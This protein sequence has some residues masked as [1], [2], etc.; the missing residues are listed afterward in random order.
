MSDGTI[1]TDHQTVQV[2]WESERTRPNSG[3][4]SQGDDTQAVVQRLGRAKS[5]SALPW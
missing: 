3:H 5:T 4:L 2:E 1:R